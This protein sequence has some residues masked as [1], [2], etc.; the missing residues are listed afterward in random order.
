MNEL[1]SSEFSSNYLS[2]SIGS[3][4]IGRNYMKRD[5]KNSSNFLSKPRIKLY[6]NN[7]N[8][9]SSNS[10]SN[11]TYEIK[12]LSKNEKI[13]TC[14]RQ[15]QNSVINPQYKSYYQKQNSYTPDTSTGRYVNRSKIRIPDKNNYIINNYSPSFERNS[16]KSKDTTISSHINYKNYARTPDKNKKHHR[17]FSRI[18]KSNSKIQRR[19]QN[20]VSSY[21]NKSTFDKTYFKTSIDS[22]R[23][24]LTKESKYSKVSAY[25]PHKKLHIFKDNGNNYK[26]ENSFEV[27]NPFKLKNNIYDKQKTEILKNKRDKK[28]KIIQCSLDNTNKLNKNVK[29]KNIVNGNNKFLNNKIR[30]H[31][32]ID[33]DKI[34]DNG[35]SLSKKLDMSNENKENIERKS[36]NNVTTKNKVNKK[37]EKNNEPI[38]YTYRVKIIRIK[39]I[40]KQ[41]E[42]IKNNDLKEEN[43]NNIFSDNSKT[44]FNNDNEYKNEESNNESYEN[45]NA[46]IGHNNNNI[47]IKKNRYKFRN[48]E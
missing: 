41:F 8:I 9:S 15:Y 25:I 40:I 48:E 6:K 24:H 43:I 4:K 17:L 14:G 37:K 22:D 34:K 18:E 20:N 19:N 42:N 36:N 16:Y 26:L 35:I 47:I 33:K 2:L 7:T 10:I 13:C 44:N 11:R 23:H 27:M 1:S 30:K 21:Y 12:T 31:N 46:I 45:E 29:V 39:K 5:D 32:K 3:G 28:D 38:I